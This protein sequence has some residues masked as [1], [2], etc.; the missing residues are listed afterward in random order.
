MDMKTLKE[1][2]N[3]ANYLD[4]KGLLDLTCKAVA[5]RIKGKTPEEIR[6]ILGD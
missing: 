6:L 4:V 3:A 2:I 1:L 5:N